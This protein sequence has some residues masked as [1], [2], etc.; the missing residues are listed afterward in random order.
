ML[1]AVGFLYQLFC[2]SE[3]NSEVDG[4]PPRLIDLL[5]IEC[6][7][8]THRERRAWSLLGHAKKVEI[9]RFLKDKFCLFCLNRIDLFEIYV[10][11][12][13]RCLK[14]MFGIFTLGS[15]RTDFRTFQS[16]PTNWEIF[17]MLCGIERCKLCGT[18]DYLRF[19]LPIGK[20]YSPWKL[21]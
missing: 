16:L 15:L 5:Y 14:F 8:Q 9:V 7:A 20:S 12:S 1:R 21:S 10:S 18:S 2:P 6:N 13:K 17:T 4:E 3:V 19:H 11:N